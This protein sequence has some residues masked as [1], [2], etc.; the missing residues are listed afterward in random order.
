MSPGARTIGQIILTPGVRRAER[1]LRGR[2]LLDVLGRGVGVGSAH[3]PGDV[4]LHDPFALGRVVQALAEVGE[5]R[6]PQLPDA[7]E[8]LG[9]RSRALDDVH[10][11]LHHRR[12]VA[13]CDRDVAAEQQLGV[14][15]VAQV[16]TTATEEDEFHHT[17][18]WCAPPSI[19]F[20][21]ASACLASRG[22]SCSR[23]FFAS[24][25]LPIWT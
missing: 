22:F 25:G 16:G 7:V 6:E 19:A 24:S 4:P 3:E 23:S 12:M 21:S 17:G 8:L 5:A 20:A 1:R 9:I 11:V 14:A 13:E 2:R 10:D 18:F 15:V